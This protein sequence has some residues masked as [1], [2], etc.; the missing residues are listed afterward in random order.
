MAARRVVDF[1]YNPPTGNR[2]IEQATPRT[3]VPHLQHVLDVASQ[4]FSSPWVSDHHQPGDRYGLECWTRL[5]WIAARYTAPLLGTVVM[6]TSYRHPPLLAKMA[7]SLQ[8]F[9][10]GR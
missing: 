3:F 5:T 2:G 9:S 8:V 4:S 7:A 1:G 6:S 10:H